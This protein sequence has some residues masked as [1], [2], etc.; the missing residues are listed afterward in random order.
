MDLPAVKILIVLASWVVGA[1][2]TVRVWKSH[3]PAFFKILLT[4][5]SFVPVIGPVVVCWISN[6]PSRLHPDVQARH[7]KTINA[8]GRWRAQDE[9]AETEQKK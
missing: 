3:D 6:F 2:L 5:L 7:P 1:W 9:Q 4:I 8:Y